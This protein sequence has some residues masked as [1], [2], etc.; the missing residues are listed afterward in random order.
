[1]NFIESLD[2]SENDLLIQILEILQNK[3]EQLFLRLLSKISSNH[4]SPYF[5]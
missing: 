4:H 5:F 3:E 2:D 1:M